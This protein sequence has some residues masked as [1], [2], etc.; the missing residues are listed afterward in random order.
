VV[1]YSYYYTGG[2]VCKKIDL[3]QRHSFYNAKHTQTHSE[4]YV[5]KNSKDAT[6]CRYLFIAKLLY[7]FRVSQHPSSGV[8]KTVPAARKNTG[9]L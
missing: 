4:I 6:V 8:L 7:T 9:I 3:L 2:T 5:N 1:N